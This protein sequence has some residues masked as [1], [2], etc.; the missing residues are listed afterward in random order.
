MILNINVLKRDKE[1]GD[2]VKIIFRSPSE[3]AITETGMSFI[4]IIVDD[5]RR[6]RVADGNDEEDNTLNVNFSDCYNIDTLL[7][8]AYE[9]GKKGEELILDYEEV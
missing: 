4:E 1:K 8:L 9:A 6:F 7:L 2:F 5:V 3:E